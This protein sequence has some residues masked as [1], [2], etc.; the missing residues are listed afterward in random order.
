LNGPIRSSKG[1]LR[2][3]GRI[4]RKES[5]WRKALTAFLSEKE[6]SGDHKN[7]DSAASAILW[8]AAPQDP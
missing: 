4:V 2:G 8:F 7:H 1:C 6:E 5:A 3:T